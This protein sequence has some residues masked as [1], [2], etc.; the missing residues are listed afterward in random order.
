MP[1]PG[2][3]RNQQFLQE[4]KEPAHEEKPISKMNKAE[5]VAKAEEMGIEV[6]SHWKKQELITEIMSA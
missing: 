4:I 5:L 3:P 1:L 2:S 6:Q